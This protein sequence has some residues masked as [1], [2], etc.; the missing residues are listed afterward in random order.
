MKKILTV[1]ALIAVITAGTAFADHPDGFGVG[2]QVGGGGTW[3]SGKFAI[4]KGLAFS[5]KLP[6]FPVYWA[7]DLEIDS[8][9]TYIGVSGDY[10]FIDAVL[11]KDIGL[12]WYL[13]F[14]AGASIGIA[15]D[16]FGLSAVAR[17]PVGLSW[18]LPL[19]A[20][21]LNAFEVYL[22][23]VPSV[24]ARITPGFKFPAGG[25]PINLG[26]RLWF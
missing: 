3:D 18:Q 6:S 12:N 11:V 16:Y 1:F 15:D 13:G 20:G 25:W 5:L 19:N 4:Q 21:P 7:I 24:G 8:G 10:Y 23:V 9:F 22:Q 2:I 17:L 14:G 26:V